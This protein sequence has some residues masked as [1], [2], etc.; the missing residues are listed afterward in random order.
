MGSRAGGH[1]S[2]GAT[3]VGVLRI[4]AE[5]AALRVWG[6]A[7]SIGYRK[8]PFKSSAKKKSPLQVRA[9][10][11]AQKVT[12]ALGKASAA[13]AGIWQAVFLARWRRQTLRA[14][15]GLGRGLD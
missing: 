4:R 3:F 15:S 10:E 1:V 11:T 5:T 12:T 7:R 13:S 14:R 6:I 8:G 9:K 2:E